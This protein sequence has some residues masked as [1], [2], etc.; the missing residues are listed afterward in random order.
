MEFFLYYM[1]EEQFLT[2]DALMIYQVKRVKTLT[3]HLVKSDLCIRT[4]GSPLCHEMTAVFQPDK[5]VLL[6]CLF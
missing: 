3:Q 2:A 1:A 5:H 4:D 6:P